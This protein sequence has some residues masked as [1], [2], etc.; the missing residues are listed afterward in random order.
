MT[1]SVVG[2]GWLHRVGMLARHRYATWLLFAIAFADSSFL[3]VPP[4]LLL[5]PMVLF[6]PERLRLLLVLC[7]LGSSLGA[8]LGYLIGYFL[9]TTVGVPLVELSGHMDDFLTYQRLV[10]EW[11]FWIIIVKAF[12]PIPFKIAAIAAGV[13]AMDPL[14]F[15]LATVLG[16]AVHFAMVG[17][18]LVLCGEKVMA[19]IQRY[20]RRVAVI[21]IVIV[22]AAVV[23]YGLR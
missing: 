16:R 20:E 1:D 5:V 9:W 12:T 13:A 3:P 11:G 18:L 19:L 10:A 17:A 8:V 21:T 2:A 23:V 22:V 14:L 15:M 4:D 6:R 7:T